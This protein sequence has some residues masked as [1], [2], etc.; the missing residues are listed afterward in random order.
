MAQRDSYD[1]AQPLGM[2]ILELIADETTEEEFFACGIA[3]L[4]MAKTV[5]LKLPTM[6]GDA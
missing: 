3:A 2:K 5:I 4:E 1:V 6:G